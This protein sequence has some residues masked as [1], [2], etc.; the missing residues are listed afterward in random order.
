VDFRLKQLIKI[1]KEAT[2]MNKLFL[3]ATL[4]ITQN[5]MADDL[6]CTMVAS[7]HFFKDFTKKEKSFLFGEVV[8]KKGQEIKIPG[9]NNRKSYSRVKNKIGGDYR[10]VSMESCFK[11]AL[12]LA[13]ETKDLKASDLGGNSDE[14]VCKSFVK[15]SYMDTTTQ[16]F[17]EGK[18]S[19]ETRK[20]LLDS[21]KLNPQSLSLKVEGDN[22][23]Y[24]T[25][26]QQGRQMILPFQG[27]AFSPE[28]L[29]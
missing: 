8:Y 4:F 21:Y 16:K 2:L 6:I 19:A 1:K 24:T 11:A 9:E 5:L 15:W 20:T 26:D 27:K 3:L 23:F 28:V 13:E 10:A 18:V 22:R 17:Q 29:D 7:C 14:L 25:T 12:E